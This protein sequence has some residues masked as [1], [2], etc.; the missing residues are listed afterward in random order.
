[1]MMHSPEGSVGMAVAAV[2]STG[3]SVDMLGSFRGYR[4]VSGD[5][6]VD[7][8]ADRVAAKLFDSG[9]SR[10]VRSEGLYR[11]WLPTISARRFDMI[12]HRSV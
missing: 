12:M 1:M 2:G 10:R 6:T 9:R 7:G 4:I 8:R 3:V 5:D 11:D